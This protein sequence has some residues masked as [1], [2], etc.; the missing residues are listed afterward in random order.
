MTFLFSESILDYVWSSTFTP[1]K[2]FIVSAEYDSNARIDRM[3]DLSEHDFVVLVA[4]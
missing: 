2:H 3:P 4:E 1:A